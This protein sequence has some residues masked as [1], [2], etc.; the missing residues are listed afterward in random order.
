LT[1]RDK[2]R[3]LVVGTGTGVGKTHVACALLRAFAERGVAAVGL[4]PVETGVAEVEEGAAD[5]RCDQERLCRA[6]NAF[7]VKHS[8]SPGFHVK[9]SLYT[10]PQGVSPHLAARIAGQRIDLGAIRGWVEGQGAPQ[11]VVE[12]AGGLFSPLGPETTNCDLVKALRP[13]VLLLVAPDR[14]GVLHDVTAT[15]GLAEVRGCPVDV[16]VLSAPESPD[17][18][19]GTN[20]AELDRLGLAHPVASFPRASEDDPT[21]IAGA[22][23]VL[24]ALDR[25]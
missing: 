8:G 20:S 18:S 2:K 4:K 14:L 16:I 1:Q 10:F 17:L 7:H 22:E 21:S 6:S 15:L 3:I 13:H 9:R 23:R 19:T 12:T 5:P 25:L 24:A 11:L